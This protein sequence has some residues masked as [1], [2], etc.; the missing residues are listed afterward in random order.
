M[1]DWVNSL[2]YCRY[3]HVQH[4]RGL[5]SAKNYSN[6]IRQY[7]IKRPLTEMGLSVSGRFTSGKISV[8]LLW[9]SFS[10][11][12]KRLMVD[13]EHTEHLY[14]GIL[15]S[16]TIM[17]SHI[18]ILRLQADMAFFPCKGLDRCGIVNQGNHHIAVPRR[19]TALYEYRSPLLIPAL[20][21]E[22]PRTF[23]IN[24]GSPVGIYS[25]GIGK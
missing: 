8:Y 7:N 4:K 18:V 20:T 16:F 24:E 12:R 1:T 17:G 2:L 6:F 19:S 5:V 3:G 10:G 11:L 23:K 13:T 22:S 14:Q 15:Q 21:M 25:A 9:L